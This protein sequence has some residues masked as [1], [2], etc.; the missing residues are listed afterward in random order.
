MKKGI[1]KRLKNQKKN[2]KEDLESHTVVKS[3][4][5]SI[6]K[7]EEVFLFLPYLLPHPRLNLP[8]GDWSKNVERR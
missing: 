3:P 2:N 6:Y 8:A 4:P 5:Y 1:N 7:V